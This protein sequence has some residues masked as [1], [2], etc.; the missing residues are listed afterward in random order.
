MRST[1]CPAC[2]VSYRLAVRYCPRCG[3]ECQPADHGSATESSEF[4]IVR[5]GQASIAGELIHLDSRPRCIRQVGDVVQVRDVI[6]A[7]SAAVSCWLAGH[8]NEKGLLIKQEV[9]IGGRW[10][11][12]RLRASVVVKT[13]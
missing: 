6:A 2:G 8:E 1:S 11:R 7:Q 3:R 5:V 13:W 12:R 10:S 4:P 9:S